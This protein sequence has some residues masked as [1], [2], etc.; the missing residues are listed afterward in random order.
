MQ[1]LQ[2]RVEAELDRDDRQG[3]VPD[4]R[5][6]EAGADLGLE[7]QH[8]AGQLGVAAGEVLEVL[9]EL[10]DV[11]LKP[12]PQRLRPGEILGVERRHRALAAVDRRRASHDHRPQRFGPLAGGEELQGPDHVDLVQGA[13]RPSGL[14]VPQDPAMHDRVDLGRR[15]QAREHVAADVR[16]DVVGA[17]KLGR[18][19]A[20]VDPG[21]VLDRGVALQPARELDAPATGDPGDRH[22]A[23]AHLTLNFRVSIGSRGALSLDLDSIL[24]RQPGPRVRELL[25]RLR[26]PA[27]L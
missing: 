13:R 4:Q 1:E 9:L 22:P 3:Q 10:G 5:T 19:G 23:T 14:R 27:H 2:A 15:Q 16:L 26:D 24:G 17:G 8:A 21:D 25:Q 7:P 18:R 6:V 20:A 12:G 11:A